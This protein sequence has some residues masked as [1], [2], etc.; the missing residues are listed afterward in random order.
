MESKISQAKIESAISLL[1]A[2]VLAI[3]NR[4]FRMLNPSISVDERRLEVVPALHSCEK[5]LELFSDQSNCFWSDAIPSSEHLL[6]V[7]HPKHFP[8]RIFHSSFLSFQFAALYLECLSH[9]SYLIVS[10]RE[11]VVKALVKIV[12]VVKSYQTKCVD[13]R[14]KR[15]YCFVSPGGPRPNSDAEIVEL[16]EKMKIKKSISNNPN[17]W[18]TFGDKWPSIKTTTSSDL[19]AWS[20]RVN[21]RHWCEEKLIDG[22]ECFL[23][24]RRA[25]RVLYASTFAEIINIASQM[26]DQLN[27]REYVDLA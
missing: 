24:Y 11:D 26:S 21:A 2:E 23:G 5:I 17:Y 22:M 20:E 8:N 10:Y 6:L 27:G 14:L 9:A 16:I 1:K 15:M 4:R 3:E 7:R 25:T 13:E 19:T 12:Q 18:T